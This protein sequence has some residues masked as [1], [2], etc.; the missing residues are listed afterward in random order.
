MYFSDESNCRV[1]KITVATGIIRTF[2]GTGS[3]LY[4]SDGGQATSTA[5][6]YPYGVAVDSS[7]IIFVC[8]IINF[9]N[10]FLLSFVIANVYIADTSNNRIRKV[11]SSTTIISTIA[12]SSTSDGYSGDSGAATSATLYEPE[13]VAVDSSGVILLL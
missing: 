4:Q 1:R 10:Y 5:L 6:N 8:S 3:C 9:L 7:G 13:G 11:L 12:G 2:A